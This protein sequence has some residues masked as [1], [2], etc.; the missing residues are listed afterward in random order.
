MS[1]GVHQPIP[2][3][4]K[5]VSSDIFLFFKNRGFSESVGFYDG[6]AHDFCC[7]HAG[8]DVPQSD[9]VRQKP[10]AIRRKPVIFVK[11]DGK[12]HFGPLVNVPQYTK[13]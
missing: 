1:V 4:C 11:P 10:R 7:M 9:R 13:H 12:Q 8:A 2:G 6:H 5:R 3:A